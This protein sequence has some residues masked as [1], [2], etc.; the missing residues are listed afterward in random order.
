MNCNEES[1]KGQFD[2]PRTKSTRVFI[3]DI[4]IKFVRDVQNCTWLSI[5]V[6]SVELAESLTLILFAFV[7][8]TVLFRDNK[9]KLNFVVI[10]FGSRCNLY[11]R[12]MKPAVSPWQRC[13]S[14][15]IIKI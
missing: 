11:V 5:V 14:K 12:I 9:K 3:P 1:L 6:A 13:I 10:Y 8:S 2:V 15:C 7:L 4:L